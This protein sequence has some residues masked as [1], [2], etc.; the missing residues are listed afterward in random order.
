MVD[1]RFKREL[2]QVRSK[3]E[4]IFN[5]AGC[6][7]GR[8]TYGHVY[9]AV[10]KDGDNTR[11]YAVKVIDGMGLSMS[12]CR[13]IAL[14]RE[15]DHVNVIALQRVFLTHHDR[16]VW[17]LFDY[18]EHDLWNIIKFHRSA[19]LNK[20][21][22]N[23][24]PALMKSILFGVLNGIA[25]LHENWILHRD[26]KPA[27]ILLMGEGH[28]RGRV[29]I[30]DMGFARLFNSP[31]KPLADL[32][33]VVVTFWYR[34]PELLLGSRHYTKAIDNWAIGCIFA[35]LLTYEPIFH[36][37]QEDIKAS[38]PYHQE[39]L[40]RIFS[41]MG[42]PS[43]EEWSDIEFMPEYTTL[44]KDFQGQNYANCSLVGY[45][46]K[47]RIRSDSR[48]FML[49]KSLLTIN[50]NLRI[51]AES[52]INNPYFQ[53]DPLPSKDVFDNMPI[54]YPK[55]EFMA[56]EEID[57]SLVTTKPAAADQQQQQQS[58][59][60][61]P[62]ATAIASTIAT[63]TAIQQ[64]NANCE[65]FKG[66]STDNNYISQ[67]TT[68]HNQ[69]ITSIASTMPQSTYVGTNGNMQLNKGFNVVVSSGFGS[70]AAATAAMTNSISNNSLSATA[71]MNNTCVNN[72]NNILNQSELLSASIHM[73]QMS[74]QEHNYLQQ[75][76]QQIEMNNRAYIHQQSNDNYNQPLSSLNRII[77]MNQQV[78]MQLH[79]QQQQYGRQQTMYPTSNYQ[80]MLADGNFQH[81]QQ[82]MHQ[83]DNS[84][85]Y[86]NIQPEFQQGS[87]HKFSN[88]SHLYIPP[89][90]MSSCSI[91]N[92]PTNSG[93]L[94][95][96]QGLMASRPIYLRN[97]NDNPIEQDLMQTTYTIQP[98]MC[99]FQSYD[100][101]FLMP[102]E[103]RMRQLQE[104]NPNHIIY[105]GETLSALRALF[106][107]DWHQQIDSFRLSLQIFE[108]IAA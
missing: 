14:L 10:P 15:L 84:I 58:S 106:Q 64:M 72:N 101:N 42:Y 19:K 67:T 60:T 30:A 31:L 6:K 27:N 91:N 83:I 63:A 49:L 39:Q 99:E 86:P 43:D 21:Q 36:C 98:G 4:D 104:I 24:P 70:S 66:S 12:S 71:S 87:Q 107:K 77:S 81:Q 75:Q 79:H 2:S 25:Y 16:K 8:G 26:L 92:N 44:I 94:P 33:P 103:K 34:A 62:N 80:T 97:N 23:H 47:H 55:R 48:A 3:I 57:D 88:N 100:P 69:R 38:S 93:Q 41:I 65:L 108:N 18:A 32:D 51:T 1:Y 50:P 37:R 74:Q 85:G 9:K 28:D 45:M 56:D 7:V 76:Q 89:Q 90:S 102:P 40:D 82:S 20:K 5:F 17:L 59:T 73:N 13:E 52:A 35:E 96:V 78:P 95:G 22:I 29:K 105:Q 11:E 68:S 61:N 46:D 53:E 54:P